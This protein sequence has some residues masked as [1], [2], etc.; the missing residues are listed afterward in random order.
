M[1]S[2]TR[3]A[4]PFS[5]RADATTRARLK[6]ALTLTVLGGL[7][8]AIALTDF[9]LCP[10]A[11]MLGIP[12]PGCGLTR[13]TLDAFCGH[14]GRALQMQPLVFFVAPIYLGAVAKW[15]FD[16]V[17]GPTGRPRKPRSSWLRAFDHAIGP[18]A[19]ALA[20]GLIAV[21]TA[22]WWG[23]FGGPVPVESYRA[24]F[25]HTLTR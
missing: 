15:S 16:Y 10:V 9:P 17:R 11:G 13:A 7:A 14:L 22:R 19:A 25:A 21:W 1:Q 4:L 24:W 2:L 20:L 23:Y 8:F 12:C 6:R 5:P 18:V 3:S